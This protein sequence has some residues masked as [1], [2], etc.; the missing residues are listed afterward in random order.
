MFPF[1]PYSK[2]REKTRWKENFLPGQSS[3]SSVNPLR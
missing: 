1:I 3:L 2:K